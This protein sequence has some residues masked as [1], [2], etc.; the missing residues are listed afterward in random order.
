MARKSEPKRKTACDWPTFSFIPA[1]IGQLCYRPTFPFPSRW[2]VIYIRARHK[3]LLYCHWHVLI[4]FP[5]FF[6]YVFYWVLLGCTLFVFYKLGLK[7]VFSQC[8]LVLL[9][10]TGSYWSSALF[11][12]ISFGFSGTWFGLTLLNITEMLICTCLCSIAF[13]GFYWLERNG[14]VLKKKKNVFSLCVKAFSGL[15]R[16]Q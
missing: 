2:L 12:L 5:W 14:M 6:F 13:T 9:G 4:G 15:V 11:Y 7:W 1:L 8:Y 10:F 16:N 3:R